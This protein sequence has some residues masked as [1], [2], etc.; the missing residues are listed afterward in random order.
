VVRPGR[1]PKPLA[2]GTPLTLVIAIAG[3]PASTKQ[4]VESVAR[5]RERRPEIVQKAFEGIR[6]LVENAPCASRPATSSAWESSSI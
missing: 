4:M 1:G 6:S 3:P 2:L 5:L